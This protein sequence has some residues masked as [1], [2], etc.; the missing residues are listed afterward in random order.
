MENSNGVGRSR[1]N[2]E[3]SRKD[4]EDR[5]GHMSDNP[6]SCSSGDDEVFSSLV[7]GGE[8]ERRDAGSVHDSEANCPVIEALD[9]VLAAM[10]WR[11]TISC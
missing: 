6:D 7:P 11:T 9:N 8:D 5:E 1:Q 2:S 3:E 10:V 4:E